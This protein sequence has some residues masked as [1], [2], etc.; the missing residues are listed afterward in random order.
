MST[1]N[2][3]D[4]RHLSVVVERPWKDV[5]AYAADPRHLPEWA[6]GLA[7]S[8]PQREIEQWSM[9]SP[10]GRVL[11]SFT[12][13]NPYGVLDHTVTL[14]SGESTLNPMRV[15][16]LGE[17][18]SEIVFTLRRGTMSEDEFA[19]DGEAVAADLL[20]LKGVVEGP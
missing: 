12:P 6:A 14:E 11:V 20:T 3:S 5:Y 10:M 8:D 18:R 13:E 19:A 2:S 17:D 9:S 15:L 4:S 16:P 1:T 7:G